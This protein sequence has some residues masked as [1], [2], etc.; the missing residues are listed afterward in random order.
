MPKGARKAKTKEVLLIWESEIQKTG[1]G[2]GVLITAR[3]PL[4]EISRAQAAV[5]LG[6]SSWTVSDLFRHGLLEG[7]K[8]GARRPRS[9]G[10]ASNAAL[11]LSAESVLNYKRARETEAQILSE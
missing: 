9:D 5:V 2:S 1:D 3:K 7:Y 11:R 6:V 10:K 8:P 4:K